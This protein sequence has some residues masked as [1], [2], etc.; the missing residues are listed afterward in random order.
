MSSE[1]GAKR[2]ALGDDGMG[3]AGAVPG[4]AV[5]AFSETLVGDVYW[6]RRE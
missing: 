6:S 1:R 5:V 2:T 3:E 4:L